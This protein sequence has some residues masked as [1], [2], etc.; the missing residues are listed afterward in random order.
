MQEVAKKVVEGT[1]SHFGITQENYQKSILALMQ[2]PASLAVCQ[3]NELEILK[4][5]KV[6]DFTQS[7]DELK[8]IYIERTK[9]EIAL[10]KKS[11][12]LTFANPQ[13]RM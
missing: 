5:D 7:R 9:Q 13:A 3:K 12:P 4:G 10:S 11:A 1:L 8:E 6:S 2:D